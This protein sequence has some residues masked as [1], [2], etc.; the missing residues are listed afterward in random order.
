MRSLSL[1]PPDRLLR[2]LRKLEALAPD[3]LRYRPSA[4][5]PSGAVATPQDTPAL[6]KLMLLY[7][8]PLAA[9]P[10]LLFGVRHTGLPLLGVVLLWWVAIWIL[11]QGLRT[12]REWRTHSN[13]RRPAL[14]R[15]RISVLVA[16]LALFGAGCIGTDPGTALLLAACGGALLF[17]A[18]GRDPARDREGAE[19]HIDHRD[20]VARITERAKARST[21]IH[22]QLRRIA[23]DLLVEFAYY[24]ATLN[25]LCGALLAQPE[26]LLQARAHLGPELDALMQATDK[27]SVVLA[28]APEDDVCGSYRVALGQMTR[29]A[30]HCLT[31]LQATSSRS[32]ELELGMLGDVLARKV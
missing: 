28:A 29:A 20:E 24:E 18:F 25:R 8:V 30:Q 32:L 16:M 13:A 27:L 31:G 22:D 17:M 15:K 5:L 26:Q 12:E 11:A 7:A 3:A 2:K 14:P 6:R 9:L 21:R 23:P 10:G 4:L 19:R 1:A